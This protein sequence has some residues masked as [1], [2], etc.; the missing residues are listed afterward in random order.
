MELTDQNIILDYKN[1]VKVVV[2]DIF[3]FPSEYDGL[4][5]WDANI[6]LARYALLNKHLFKDKKVIELHSG[7]GIASIVVK[8][9]SEALT[10]AAT[11]S[12]PEIVEN[13]LTN[14]K[15]NSISSGMIIARIAW[16]EY[17]N[18]KTKFDFVM[19]AD[20]LTKTTSLDLL[21]K[22]IC[23]LLPVGG[24]ALFVLPARSLNIADSFVA[25]LDADEFVVTKTT[26]ED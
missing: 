3:N 9:Y 5:I 26:L 20:L 15:K 23:K 4:H 18:F 21:H 16:E 22:V 6:I 1:K 12:K 7:T 24:R 11:D 2:G 13:I 14:C 19:G 17:A 10:V 25:Q 8:K